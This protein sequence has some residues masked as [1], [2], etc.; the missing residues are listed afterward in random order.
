MAESL[1]IAEKVALKAQKALEP[2]LAEMVANKWPADFRKIM[3]EAVADTAS[4]LARDTEQR[5]TT[6]KGERG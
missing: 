3:W 4:A 5:P 2:L 1:H 6:H